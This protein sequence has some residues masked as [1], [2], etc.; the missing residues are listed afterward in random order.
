[1]IYIPWGA[2]ANITFYY[3]IVKFYMFYKVFFIFNYFRGFDFLVF[4][5]LV[6][7]CLVFYCLSFYCM[8]T[9]DL[10]SDWSKQSHEYVLLIRN[11]D[12]LPNFFRLTSL[13]FHK[14]WAERLN[15][16]DA[17]IVNVGY[18]NTSI[19]NAL[20]TWI[21]KFCKFVHKQNCSHDFFLLYKL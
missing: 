5:C 8:A 7:Y 10:Y 17:W 11:G 19:Y 6:I 12:H 21:G 4:Y 20:I 16:D 9:F 3:L 14:W 15:L 13:L 18:K 1:M 2:A